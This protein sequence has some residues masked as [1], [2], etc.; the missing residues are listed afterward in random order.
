VATTRI[1]VRLHHASD[2]L[3]GAAFGVGLG[4]ALRPFVNGGE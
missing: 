3:A 2:V 4:L 1:Y